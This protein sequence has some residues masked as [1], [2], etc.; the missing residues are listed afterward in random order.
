MNTDKVKTLSV[1]GYNSSE[2]SYKVQLDFEKTNDGH[3]VKSQQICI[4]WN[5]IKA[6]FRTALSYQ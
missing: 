1:K 4:T 5:T 6:L 2:K 3:Q